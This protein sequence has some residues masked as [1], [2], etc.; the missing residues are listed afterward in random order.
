MYPIVAGAVVLTYNIVGLD[1]G[2]TLVLDR[3][4][5]AG[6]YLGNISNW[7]DPLI[8]NINPTIAEKLPNSSI[9]VVHR[10]DSSGT[11]QIFTT[12]LA[13]FSPV[14]KFYSLP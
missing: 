1:V 2:D 8:L 13:S 9:Y 3:N 4:I 6:I 14:S 12:A 5:I 7:R 11:T 10:S